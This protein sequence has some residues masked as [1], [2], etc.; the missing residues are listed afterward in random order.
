MCIYIYATMGNTVCLVLKLIKDQRQSG[1][2]FSNH[3][4]SPFQLPCH[5]CFQRLV[6]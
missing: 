2:F 6:L 1:R 4:I 5:S 3:I